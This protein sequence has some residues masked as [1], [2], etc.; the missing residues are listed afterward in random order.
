MLNFQLKTDPNLQIPEGYKKFNEKEVIISY[1]IPKTLAIPE[2]KRISFEIFD[3]I[4]YLALEIHFLSPIVSLIPVTV[5]KGVL[6]KPKIELEDKIKDH[7]VPINKAVYKTQP[8]PT[9]LSFTPNIKLEVAKLVGVYNNDM[10][11]ECAR[12]V[13][14]LIYSVHSNSFELI[15]RNPKP[16]GSIQNKALQQKIFEEA[17]AAAETQKNEAKR[18][19]R[20]ILVEEKLKQLRGWKIDKLKEEEELKTKEKELEELKNKQKTELKNKEKFEIEK[21]I[22]EFKIRK[23]EEENKKIMIEREN[24][25]KIE[26]KKKK[27][28]EEFLREAKKKL[29]ENMARKTEEKK[30]SLAKNFE[31]KTKDE[32]KKDQRKLLISKLLKNKVVVI[33][34]KNLKEQVYIAMIDPGVIN[35]FK[36]YNSAIEVLFAYYCK[37]APLPNSDSSSMSLAGFTKFVN[38]FP[39]VPS[40]TT[41]DQVLRIYKGIT[42]AKFNDSGINSSEFKEALINIALGALKVLEKE[43]GKKLESYVDLVKEFIDWINLPQDPKKISDFLKM[44]NENL[45]TMN[46][47]DKKRNKNTLIRTLTKT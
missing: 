42:K 26:A 44:L 17:A 4:L 25:L 12:L 38:Q 36:S 13:D 24:F 27:E 28:R 10:L 9:Y 41:S 40:L 15:S 16:A 46:P 3:S 45:P 11:L 22:K 33:K 7:G 18:K 30:N 6:T 29:M 37:Q 14:D 1:S 32:Q 8:L 43:A 47:R 19:L 21:K 31:E 39:I 23:E 20:K 2:S 35:L 34:E 5:I